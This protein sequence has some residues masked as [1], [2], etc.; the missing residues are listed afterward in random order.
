MP[1]PRASEFGEL[2]F[3]PNRGGEEVLA[4]V[5]VP[6]VQDQADPYNAAAPRRSTRLRDR[7]TAFMGEEVTPEQYESVYNAYME[8]LNGYLP[9]EY[10][11]ELQEVVFSFSSNDRYI[12]YAN[13]VPIMEDRGTIRNEQGAVPFPYILRETLTGGDGDLQ[14]NYLN[15]IQKLLRVDIADTIHSRSP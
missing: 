12:S 3:A 11:G 10:V 1:A 14:R 15:Q 13:V 2:P 8:K 7:P 9:A 5:P 6:E 4:D